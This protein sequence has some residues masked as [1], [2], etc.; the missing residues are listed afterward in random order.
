MR[1]LWFT[2]TPLTKGKGSAYN[3]E[4]W[5]R[6]MLG[7]LKSSQDGGGP[8]IGVAFNEGHKFRKKEI[9]GAT[10]YCL[11]TTVPG[12]LGRFKQMHVSAKQLEKDTEKEWKA[13]EES[14]LQ[15]IED[16]K[17]DA[18]HIWGSES[19]YG[20]VAGRTDIPCVLHIQGLLLPCETAYFPPHMSRKEYIR[21]DRNPLKIITRQWELHNWK[22]N[23][24]REAEIMHRVGHVV[25]RTFWDRQLAALMAPQAAYHECG[26]I[27]RPAFYDDCQR[28]LPRRLTLVSTVSRAM[29]K[30]YD[31][32]LRTAAVLRQMCG[33]DFE[34]RVYGNVEPRYAEAVTGIKP[35][36]VG[37]RLRGVVGSKELQEALATCSIYVHPS[38]IDNSPNS[39]CEAQI[40][41]C[42]VVATNVGGI[43][44]LIEEGVT[45]YTVPANDPYQMAYR[46]KEL[47][48]DPERLAAMGVKARETA[49][50]RHSRE[51]VTGQLIDI[52]REI[53]GI[54]D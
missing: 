36:T 16:F 34:W 21:Q 31:M 51:R 12:R 9:D 7:A 8:E 45:G 54:H 17:P 25:G 37:V 44:S 4:G 46:I 47:A 24:E 14:C 5:V 28:R 11:P 13:Q 15:A 26:E 52:Y 38:Y 42:P 32:I 50:E 23:R 29:Y 22:R 43:P 3:G 20:L 2:N 53:T 49:L 30:G 19:A 39:L 48:A 35:E 6:S 1:I 27:L 18:I 40:L 33:L 10:C 41:G